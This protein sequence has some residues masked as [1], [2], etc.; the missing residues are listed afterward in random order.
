MSRR[1]YDYIYFLKG[2]QKK[3][4]YK[5]LENAQKAAEKLKDTIG[6]ILYPYECKK[7]SWWHL[8]KKEP[9]K[10]DLP[11]KQELRCVASGKVSYKTQ[12]DA[13]IAAGN[14]A[15]GH[16]HLYPYI[17]TVCNNWHLTSVKHILRLGQQSA[18][19]RAYAAL[20]QEPG[21]TQGSPR[22]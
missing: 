5:S 19:Y 10:I 6:A 13:K 14:R 20:R 8:T 16:A 1:L 3:V 21:K 9:K 11:V 15:P 7:C 2:C 4:E 22:L 12:E 17:C 18:E